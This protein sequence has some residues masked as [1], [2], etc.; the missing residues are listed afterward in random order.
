MNWTNKA[1]AAL[2][3]IALALA[4]CAHYPLNEPL[5]GNASETA[6]RFEEQ[7][8]GTN[9]NE[10][11][12]CVI[13]SGGGT[14]A[15]ALSYGVLQKLRDTQIVWKGQTKRLLDEVDC[16]SSVSGGAFTAAYYGLFGE[17]VFQDFRERFLDHDVES[18]LIGRALS[19]VNWFRLAS[20]NFSR[21]DLAAEYY[22]EMI[23][24]RKTFRALG[25]G[26]RR[27]FVIINSTNMANGERFEFTQSEFNILG[28][29][30]GTYPVARAVAASSAFPFLLSPLSLKNYPAPESV[31]ITTDMRLGL[32]DFYTNRR[33][34]Q[35]AVNRIQYADVAE[36]PYI[37][38]MD[39]GLADNIGLRPIEAAYRRSSGFIRKLINDGKIEKFVLLIVNA[40]TEMQ[41]QLSKKE[42][43]PGL[44]TVA[45]KTATV[46]LDN[47]SFESIELIK[48]LRDERTRA[49]G[50]ITACQTRLD[51]CPQAGKLP[52]FSRDIQPYIVE[53]DFKAL[54]DAERRTYFLSL[55]TNFRL[56]RSD[57]QKLVDVGGELLET[58]PE[59]EQ[60]LKD[61]QQ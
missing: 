29:D 23:F 33:R 58:D 45:Y 37:H 13:L 19:P 59:F 44:L 57:V 31:K 61:L 39:G 54:P 3:G 34:Y 20:P 24:E 9:T 25:E 17:R 52:K 48:E 35:W 21:I 14:R 11:F 27:P 18:D 41:D 42:N 7:P 36:R 10:L 55:P 60:L 1:L 32:E 12:I 26:G 4:G 49:Q 30:L 51:A 47:Y 6:Y 16:I 38:L 8:S 56:S 46:A 43:P 28:S 5:V 22:D 53:V 40:R 2:I 15:A 50:V